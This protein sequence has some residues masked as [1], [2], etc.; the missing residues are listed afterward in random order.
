MLVLVR[1]ERGGALFIFVAEPA[2]GGG[3][4]HAVERAVGVVGL[5]HARE[6]EHA[7][8]E[9]R[10]PDHARGDRAQQVG[11]RADAEREQAHHDHE[12]QHRGRDVGTAPPREQ[13]VAPDDGSQNGGHGVSGRG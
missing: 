2:L 7:G 12:E 4:Q 9:R 3:E 5:E 6:R 11:L 10:H 1:D 13:Q 8:E